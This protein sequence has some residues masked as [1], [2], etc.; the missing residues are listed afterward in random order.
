MSAHQAIDIRTNKS[1]SRRTLMSI[2]PKHV[3]FL[4]KSVGIIIAFRL[5]ERVLVVSYV[6]LLAGACGIVEHA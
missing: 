5:F 2:V 1:D 4:G 6:A 3:F